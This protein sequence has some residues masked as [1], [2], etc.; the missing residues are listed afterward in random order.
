MIFTAEPSLQPPIQ[1]VLK[2]MSHDMVIID[3][4]FLITHNIPL[5]AVTLFSESPMDA[6][7]NNNN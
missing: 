3:S 7:V 6:Q 4:I 5:I 2:A 1:Y